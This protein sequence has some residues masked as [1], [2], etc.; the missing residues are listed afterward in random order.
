MTSQ[1]L[2]SFGLTPQTGFPL[3]SGQHRMERI[4]MLKTW[5]AVLIAGAIGLGAA[6]CSQT[7][8]PNEGLGTVGGAVV[9]GLIGS[10][11]GGGAGKAAAIAGG[12][13]LGGFVGNQIGKGLD[14]EAQQRAYEAQYSAFDSGSRS[15]WRAPSGAYGYI[16][17][18]P[19]YYD[20]QGQCRRY[21]HTIYVNGR[22][23]QG[24]GVACRNPD[25][26][27]QIVS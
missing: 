23:Q 14:E 8:G 22:P 18:G 2:Q 12:A 13:L 3:V 21:T 9:G 11:F 10:R 19:V 4:R 17:P 20:P 24:Q 6:G 16:E 26:S 15:D 7:A 25:G 5:T 1:L 27:W